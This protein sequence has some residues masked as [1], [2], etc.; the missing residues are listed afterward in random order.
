MAVRLSALRAGR[1]AALYCQE[2]SWY[3]FLLVDE[4]TPRATVRLEEL[5]KLENPM[6]P[7]GIKPETF[8]LVVQSLNLNPQ[9]ISDNLIF[10][11]IQNEL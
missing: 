4:S 5:D 7:S 6:I 9:F 3:S 10:D 2:N 1:P 11:T 8:W